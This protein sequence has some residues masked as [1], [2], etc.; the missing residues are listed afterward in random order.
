MEGRGCPNDMVT[1]VYVMVGVSFSWMTSLILCDKSCGVLFSQNRVFQC[2]DDL[3][4]FVRGYGLPNQCTPLDPYLLYEVNEVLVFPAQLAEPCMEKF[5]MHRQFICTLF[6]FL[7]FFF[8][9]A[10]FF[11]FFLVIWQLGWRGGGEGEGRRDRGRGSFRTGQQGL[12]ISCNI[13][14]SE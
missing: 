7:S 13:H 4:V 5:H 2:V 1:W 10:S 11:F 3:T 9:T 12:L 14:F 6:A 8:S